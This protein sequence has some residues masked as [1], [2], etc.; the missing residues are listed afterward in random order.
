MLKNKY[1]LLLKCIFEVNIDPNLCS[2]LTWPLVAQ[3]HI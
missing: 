3:L 2:L 1:Q